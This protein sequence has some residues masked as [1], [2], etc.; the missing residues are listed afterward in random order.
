MRQW[1]EF[2]AREF[3]PPQAAVERASEGPRT[4]SGPLPMRAA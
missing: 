4:A 2:Q 1:E 3:R